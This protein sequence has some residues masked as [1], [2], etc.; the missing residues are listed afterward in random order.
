MLGPQSYRGSEHPRR[1]HAYL[2]LTGWKVLA[3]DGR[4]DD[5]RGVRA[6]RTWKDLPINSSSHRADLML[7]VAAVPNPAEGD[8]GDATAPWA[9]VPLETAS[10]AVLTMTSCC[11]DHFWG[12]D[13]RTRR[14]GARSWATK[15]LILAGLL[16]RNFRALW[17]IPFSAFL[18]ADIS[19]VLHRCFD[20][21][22]STD[23]IESSVAREPCLTRLRWTEWNWGSL[24]HDTLDVIDKVSF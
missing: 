3:S 6:V 2:G 15:G 5:V 12:N 7:W 9:Q 21:G 4:W 16:P 8:H 20:C 17:I 22:I 11:S 18:G 1:T 10:C 13:S 23:A 19:N 24:G 14:W